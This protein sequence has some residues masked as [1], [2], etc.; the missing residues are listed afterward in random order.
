MALLTVSRTPT[1]D[2]LASYRGVETLDVERRLTMDDQP[3]QMYYRD[4]RSD[5]VI[6]AQNFLTVFKDIAFIVEMIVELVKNFFRKT[7]DKT[8]FLSCSDQTA[9]HA[10]LQKQQGDSEK[11]ELK[12]QVFVIPGLGDSNLW[13]PLLKASFT[14][15]F[16]DDKKT[17]FCFIRNDHNGNQDYGTTFDAI[18]DMISNYCT[19]HPNQP[20]ALVGV[21]LGGRLCHDIEVQLSLD[22]KKNP[23]LVYA[24]A[25]AFESGLA[26]E[27]EEKHP[28]LKPILDPSL[29][30]RFIRGSQVT[31]SL[32]EKSNHDRQRKT[33]INDVMASN[34]MLIEK[35]N[36]IPYI[37]NKENLLHKPKICY[38]ASHLG[39]I[40]GCFGDCSIELADFFA[41]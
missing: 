30:E 12:N 9:V 29:F 33:V 28:C 16:P 27:V 7:S 24:M 6:F 23:V 35:A 5:L 1:K 19:D 31:K 39:V 36:A 22:K 18:Y 40:K 8:Q 13:G 34:D 15:T 21:S 4:T 20:I 32:I 26:T 38:G 11:L 14:S 17:N 37:E 2:S 41:S 10:F 3:P 25:S